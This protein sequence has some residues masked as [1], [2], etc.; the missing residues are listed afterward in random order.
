MLSAI[1]NKHL[2]KKIRH[3]QRTSIFDAF[4]F[5][6]LIHK[7]EDPLFNELQHLTR[8]YHNEQLT[9]DIRQIQKK[10]HSL[11]KKAERKPLSNEEM[12]FVVEKLREMTRN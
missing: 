3:H 7:I 10:V 5:P 4:G 8:R 12:E 9:H 11:V 2:R 6:Q 1:K